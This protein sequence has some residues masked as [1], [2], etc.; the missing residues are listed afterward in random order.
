MGSGASLPSTSSNKYNTGNDA[1]VAAQKE[2]EEL[3]LQLHNEQKLVQQFQAERKKMEEQQQVGNSCN[4]IHIHN[5]KVTLKLY[6]NSSN[7]LLISVKYYSCSNLCTLRPFI[8]NIYR[9]RYTTIVHFIQNILICN[10][11]DIF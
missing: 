6:I 3:K 7:S 2:I 5:L 8:I 11:F 4:A 10:Y 1:M 9:L